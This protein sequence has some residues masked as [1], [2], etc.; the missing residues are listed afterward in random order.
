MRKDQTLDA[1]LLCLEAKGFKFS[2]D[3]I[4]FIYFGKKYTDASDCLVKAAVEITLKAQKQF[5]GSFFLSLLERLKEQKT[6]SRI[7]AM[8]FAESQGLLK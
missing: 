7:E 8:Q 4:A 5:D 2:D 6:D 1:Y 3:M